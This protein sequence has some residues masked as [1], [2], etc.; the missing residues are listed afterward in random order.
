VRTGGFNKRDVKTLVPPGIDP[1]SVK[2]K[3]DP[4]GKLT[5]V[6]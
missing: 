3:I 4:D 5:I 6:I 2:L 1:D